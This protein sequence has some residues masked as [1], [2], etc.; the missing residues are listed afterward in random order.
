[1]G[2]GEGQVCSGSG[3]RGQLDSGSGKKGMGVGKVRVRVW[4]G[5][6]DSG[7]VGGTGGQR[8]CG[9]DRWTAGV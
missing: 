7:S 6:V 5:Q 1:M 9:R 3:G 2:V 4:E 8:E